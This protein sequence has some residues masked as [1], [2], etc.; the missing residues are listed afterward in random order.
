[1][2]KTG[3]KLI[4]A[5]DNQLVELAVRENS[6]E[7]F[8][9]I[10]SRYY[11][12]VYG[13]ISRYVSEPEEIQDIAMESFAKA[14]KQLASYD[15]SKRFSTWILTIARNTAFDHKDRDKVRSKGLETTSLEGVDNEVESVPDGAKSPEEEVIDSQKHERFMAILEGLPS[16]YREIASLCLVDN[17]GYKEIAEKTGLPIGTVK[18]R[19]FRAKEL[20]TKAMEEPE[21]EQ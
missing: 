12:G 13:H 2:A 16:L 6:Q 20:I 4:D 3:S 17:L 10:F 7:A 19:I 5:S 11:A 8:G 1:M 15:P 21:E 18:T 9:L 14:F